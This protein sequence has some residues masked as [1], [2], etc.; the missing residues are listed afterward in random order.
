M[1]GATKEVLGR[2][3]A[4]RGDWAEA[5]RLLQEVLATRVQHDFAGQFPSA[6]DALAAVAAG[7]ESY[8]ETARTL[9][10]AQGARERLENGALGPGRGPLPG[11][12]GSGA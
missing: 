8:A 6:L 4:A 11:T 2:C 12:R 7:L 5:E 1:A 3:A 10:A 9:G